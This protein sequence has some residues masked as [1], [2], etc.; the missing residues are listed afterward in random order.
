MIIAMPTKNGILLL[1]ASLAAV[2]TAIMNVGFAT[3]MIASLLCALTIS[4]FIMAQF[5]L[6][7]IT[8]TRDR[9]HDAVCGGTLQL[10][11][12][13]VNRTYLYRMPVVVSE[14]LPFCRGGSLDAVIPALAP[15]GSCRIE[16]QLTPMKRGHFPLKTLRLGQRRSVRAVPEIPEVPPALQCDGHAAD[17]AAGK[18]PSPPRSRIQH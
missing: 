8:I 17:R 2:G 4:C 1:L 11:V 12:I 14:K 10:P 5:S 15:R 6:H 16:R 9:T 13:A 3:A 18:S 7:G